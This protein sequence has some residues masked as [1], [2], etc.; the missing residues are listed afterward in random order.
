MQTVAPYKNRD[1]QTDE[2]EECIN[3][4][5]NAMCAIL[6]TPEGRNMFVAAEVSLPARLRPAHSCVSV[7]A[8]LDGIRFEFLLSMKR[9]MQNFYNCLPFLV[10]PKV[11]FSLGCI[12]A[13]FHVQ[14]CSRRR[15]EEG[16]SKGTGRTEHA[17]A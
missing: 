6:M 17:V 13:S 3:N 2:E 10:I 15:A 5:F 8:L 11:F 4:L 16:A 14:E 7:W 9:N 1:P 12:A